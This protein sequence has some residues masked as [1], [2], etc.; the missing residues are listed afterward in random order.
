[1]AAIL[2][3]DDGGSKNFKVRWRGAGGRSCWAS[4]TVWLAELAKLRGG[5]AANTM[6]YQPIVLASLPSLRLFD[7]AP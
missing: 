2:E 3:L 5:S 1:M 7:A 4:V 6:A